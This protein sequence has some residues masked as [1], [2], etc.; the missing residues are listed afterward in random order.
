MTVNDPNFEPRYRDR[1][2]SNYNNYNNPNYN[3]YNNYNNPNSNNYGGWNRGSRPGQGR[4]R[5][6]QVRIY[7]TPLAGNVKNVDLSP[8]NYYFSN[9]TLVK[10]GVVNPKQTTIYTLDKIKNDDD[11]MIVDFSICT[12]DLDV[13]VRT[14][15]KTDNSNSNTQSF[16]RFNLQSSFSQG[17]TTYVI[18]NL[19]D[20]H[21]YLYVEAKKTLVNCAQNNDPNCAKNLAYIM[22][23]Y[24][25][26]ERKYK[27]SEVDTQLSARI[28]G[29]KQIW[30][31]VPS[32]KEMDYFGNKRDMEDIQFNPFMT[33]N[34]DEANRFWSVCYLS[35]VLDEGDNNTVRYYK[36]IKLNG[37]NEYVYYADETEVKYY[38]SILAKNLK[39]GELIGYQPVDKEVPSNKF[40]TFLYILLIMFI[41]GLVAFAVYKFVTNGGLSALGMGFDNSSN[42]PA[43][44]VDKEFGGYR[45]GDKIKY[46]TINSENF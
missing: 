10:N 21:I 24:S 43:S 12:G 26:N 29:K 37:D 30:I 44:R 41:V 8:F 5:E 20:N 28:G 19:K 16:N 15:P 7:V 6:S 39:T 3:N 2:H 34:G 27:S 1:E 32:I 46:T 11:K 13:D 17:K 45:G 22:R 35:H 14:Q 23:Y 42:M 36:D 31:K 33:K 25:T 18:S 40:V 4:D 38:F 9:T